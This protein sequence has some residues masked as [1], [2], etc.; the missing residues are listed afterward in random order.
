MTKVE[1]KCELCESP[2]SPESI[3]KEGVCFFIPPLAAA[4]KGD[5]LI[6]SCYIPECGREIR[7]FKVT[8]KMPSCGTCDES[9][10]H[11]N[12][13]LGGRCHR[14]APVKATQE[15][16]TITISCYIP[17]CAKLIVAFNVME[18]EALK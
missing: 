2:L 14:G 5:T 12:L 3:T 18:I 11:R 1:K 13:V 6:L 9:H 10:A 8:S 4:L 16:G 15:K 7:K 17:E